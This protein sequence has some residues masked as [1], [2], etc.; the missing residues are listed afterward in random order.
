MYVDVGIKCL[1]CDYCANFCVC[2]LC[3]ANLPAAFCFV[4]KF[5]ICD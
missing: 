4:L 2:G 1:C 3:E 5:I